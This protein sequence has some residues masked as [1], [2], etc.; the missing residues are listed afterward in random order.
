MP[1]KYGYSEKIKIIDVEGHLIDVFVVEDLTDEELIRF[2][3]IAMNKESYEHAQAIFAE[4]V[5]RDI[6]LRL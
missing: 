6:K 2:F 5:T 4:A 1:R 3:D